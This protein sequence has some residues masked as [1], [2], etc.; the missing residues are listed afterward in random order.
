MLVV[1][2]FPVSFVAVPIPVVMA[3]PIFII[4]IVVPAIIVGS[5]RE[6]GSNDC[7]QG[8]DG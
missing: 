3:V 6:G 8:E 1:V 2:I 4:P 5:Q 7:P